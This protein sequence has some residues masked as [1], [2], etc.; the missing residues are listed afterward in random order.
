V[1]WGHEL[2]IGSSALAE[3]IEPGCGRAVT[4]D[5]AS[6]ARAVR[7]LSHG[8]PLHRRRAAGARAEQFDRPSSVDRMAAALPRV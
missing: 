1:S 2:L 5:P 7:H 8:D 6:F 3:I 4:D